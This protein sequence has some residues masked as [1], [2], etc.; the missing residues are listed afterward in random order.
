MWRFAR[1]PARSNSACKSS[2]DAA[3]P[4]FC[5]DFCG[6]LLRV[7]PGRGKCNEIAAAAAFWSSAGLCV[8]LW[9]WGFVLLGLFLHLPLQAELPGESSSKGIILWEQG[10]LQSH[11]PEHLGTGGGN[12][13]P[14]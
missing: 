10:M 1:V 4:S 2:P 12:F 8:L 14:V 13:N 5:S 6:C 9:L 3:D 11:P 7:R